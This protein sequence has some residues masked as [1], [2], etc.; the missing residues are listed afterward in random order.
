MGG[1]VFV[2]ER[3]IVD[4]VEGIEQKETEGG[5]GLTPEKR[6]RVEVELRCRNDTV[7][8]SQRLTH[9]DR[10]VCGWWLERGT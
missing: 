8:A 7:I 9:C 3:N 2:R 6:E 5:D 1:G 10:C 4:G